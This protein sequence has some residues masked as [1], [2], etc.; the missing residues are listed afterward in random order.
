MAL[1]RTA[2]SNTA[3]P[4]FGLRANLEVVAYWITLGAAAGGLGGALVGGVGGRLAMLLLRLTSSDSVRGL[5]SDDGFI[6]GRFDFFDSAE[7]MFVTAIMGATFGLFVV[8]GRPFF[9][10]RGMPFAWALAGAVI[11]GAIIVHEDGVDFTVLDPHWLAVTLFVVIPGVGA[12][13]IAWLTDLFPRFWWRRRALTALA[14][15]AMMPSLVLFP[16]AIAA[17]LVG[18]I[19][20]L[21]MCSA[22]LR[23]MPTW[24]PAR[25]TAITVFV[26]LVTLAL[27]DLT[28]DAN[29]IV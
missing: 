10:K 9:P 4:G 11:G 18:A 23:S 7:L 21:A 6:I 5:E 3:A 14:G 27:V 29:A 8:A 22:E 26:L 25:I 2:N 24:M 15:L 28:R 19:W 20:S 16:V 12:G 1:T 13:L 17:L